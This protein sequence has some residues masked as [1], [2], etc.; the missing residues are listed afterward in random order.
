[1]SL[2]SFFS[3]GG[4]PFPA[5]I[6]RAHGKFFGSNLGFPAASQ[7]KLSGNEQYDF[8]RGLTSE[9]LGNMRGD[10]SS[11]QNLIAQGGLPPAIAQQFRIARGGLADTAS[12][13]N[14]SNLAALQQRFLTSGGQLPASAMTDF[15][16]EGQK[17]TG[18]NLFN[19]TN[20]LNMG[21]AQTALTN[22]NSLY[23]RIDSLRKSMLGA[24]QDEESN[25]RK[26]QIAAMMAELQ[27][28]GMMSNF[29]G[30]VFGSILGAA[31]RS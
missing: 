30:G 31:G 18:E 4:G 23:D 13:M 1:M 16:L 7:L 24:G 10:A 27:R 14:N 2:G 28:R 19:A 9:A 26:A 15:N 3:A 11:Y 29:L 20:E 12:R 8:G 17:T 21:E 5:A 6:R 22:T 25:A